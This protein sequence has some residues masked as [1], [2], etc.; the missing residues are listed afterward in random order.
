VITSSATLAALLD[1]ADTF[2]FGVFN[3]EITTERYLF[4][5]AVGGGSVFRLGATSNLMTLNS[6]SVTLN[7]TIGTGT[8]FM[9]LCWRLATSERRV[10]KD[11]TSLASNATDSRP[12]WTL[13]NGNFMSQN[14]GNRWPGRCKGFGIYANNSLEGAGELDALKDAVDARWTYPGM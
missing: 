2:V 9:A 4:G 12:V 3:R 5:R 7:G 14:N 13:S 1:S 8:D 11:F 6:G 10:F